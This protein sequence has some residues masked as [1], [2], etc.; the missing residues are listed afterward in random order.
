M[1]ESECGII[2]RIF[3]KKSLRSREIPNQ[4]CSY[5]HICDVYNIASNLLKVIVGF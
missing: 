3:P 5:N 4:K 1:W 2:F